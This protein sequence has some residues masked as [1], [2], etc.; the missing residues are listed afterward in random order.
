M[1]RPVQPLAKPVLRDRGKR[2]YRLRTGVRRGSAAY[3]TESGTARLLNLFG[4]TPRLQITFNPQAVCDGQSI[5]RRRVGY[6]F[7]APQRGASEFLKGS[8]VE[9]HK[10]R[11][12]YR[13]TNRHRRRS[14]FRIRHRHAKCTG[15]PPLGQFQNGGVWRLPSPNSRRAK[16]SKISALSASATDKADRKPGGALRSPGQTTENDGLSHSARQDRPQKTMVCPT[17]P[18]DN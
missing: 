18:W 10:I 8:T 11:R 7:T 6:G 15:K 9:D 2:R 4:E 1:R 12:F 17:V 14:V 5:G 13:F 3:F 16:P